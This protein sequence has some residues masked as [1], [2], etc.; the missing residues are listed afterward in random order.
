MKKKCN[1]V[2]LPTE[3]EST[4]HLCPWDEPSTL[5]IL[6]NQKTIRGDSIAHHLYITSNGEI[7]K[8][9]WCLGEHQDGT[10]ILLQ[11]HVINDKGFLTEDEGTWYKEYTSK[12]IASTDPELTTTEII[13]V[14]DRVH[15]NKL[16]FNNQFVSTKSSAELYNESDHYFKLL[17][18]LSESFIKEYVK[19]PVDEVMVEY[20][21]IKEN[22]MGTEYIYETHPLKLDNN[23]IITSPVEEKM[24]TAEEMRMNLMYAL[25]LFAA[26]R[27]LTPTSVQMKEVNEW[28]DNWIKENL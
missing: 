3:N 24:Y 10:R 16:D 8:G 15:S 18:Q 19:N 13:K 22:V 9:D 21:V 17:P 20:D 14:G 27:K 7:K 4:I 5:M 26:S 2:M 28:T 1:V 25:S 12:V 6:D 23:Q 11:A